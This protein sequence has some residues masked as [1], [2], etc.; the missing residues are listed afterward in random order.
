[1][2]AENLPALVTPQ[3]H[4]ER[5]HL[6][7][8]DTDSWTSVLPDVIDL[9]RAINDTDFIPAGLR[10]SVAGTA[11]AILYGRE[12]GLGPITTLQNTYVVHGKVGVSAEIMR[13]MVFSAGHQI[14]FEE[15]TSATCR[16]RG[17]RAGS[18]DWST[19]Q[20]T[21][22][23]A[24]RAGLV[25]KDSGWVTFPRRMLQARASS[26]LCQMVFPDVIHG[27]VTV[28]E[29]ED[30]A[31]A[32]GQI[33]AETTT[34]QRKAGAKKAAQTPAKA[35][36]IPS[37]QPA[38]DSRPELPPLPGEPGYNTTP[39][40]PQGGPAADPASLSTDAPAAGT[41]NGSAAEQA[42]STPADAAAEPPDVDVQQADADVQYSE[43]DDI[44]VIEEPPAP[45][46]SRLQKRGI[47]AAFADYQL[48]DPQH[49][50]QR[51]HY[52]SVI[53][54]RPVDTTSGLS[55]AEA[56][57]LIQA[58]A[59]CNTRADLDTLVANTVQ[60]AL[61]PLDAD[62]DPDPEPPDEPA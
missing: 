15:S 50:N 37:P 36:P 33:P 12:V 2:T 26:E 18:D 27:F 1:M 6:V 52:T 31:A 13:A 44:E 58:L 48:A 62:P 46:L 51:L 29:L 28:E 61:D 54:G 59:M 35:E 20:W 11:A 53:V 34:V 39:G 8:P 19:V 42:A 45:R 23:D 21:I 9:A 17:R 57:T 41:T 4:P 32:N 38:P 16:V 47:L 25:R 5:E 7:S 3:R 30:A 55:R 40:V 49:R 10:K 60:Y 43:P 14:V 22:D 56:S 24:K